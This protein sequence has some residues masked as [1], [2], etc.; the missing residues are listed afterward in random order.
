LSKLAG[1]QHWQ[2]A[3]DWTAQ[4]LRVAFDPYTRWALLAIVVLAS[5]S[6]TRRA[7]TF[8]KALVAWGWVV[9]VLLTVGTFWFW[10]WYIS[11]LIVPAALI[12]PGRLL[13]ATLI[14]CASSLTLYAIYPQAAFPLSELVGWPGLIIMAP[15]LLYVWWSR[16]PF[17]GRISI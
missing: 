16:Q 3:E 1:A 10:P 2:P 17:A 5:L 7:R 4:A 6:I 12:G 13:N 11:W 14:F 9:F 15:P 8:D